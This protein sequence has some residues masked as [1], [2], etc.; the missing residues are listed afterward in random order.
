ME[1]TL[2]PTPVRASLKEEWVAC[3][4]YSM[5]FDRETEFQIS[6]GELL[7]AGSLP[8][9][10]VTSASADFANPEAY[11]LE[12]SKEGI[13]VTAGHDPGWLYAAVTLLHLMNQ[14]DGKLPL[15]SLYDYP[16]MGHRAM[17]LTFAQE[18]VQT[19]MDYLRY[20]L[21]EMAK[22]KL[23]AC[24]LYLETF[25]EFD[26]LKGFAGPGAMKVE[27]AKELVA[28]GRR[29]NIQVIPALNVMGHCGDLLD[30][31]R[32]R[33]L[34][35]VNGRDYDLRS[36]GNTGALCARN[37]KVREFIGRLL[38]EACEVF[39][40]ELIH[41]GGDE[42]EV[43][44]KCPLCEDG[45]PLKLYI[46]YF[47]FVRD[48]LRAH[49]RRMGIW[50]DILVHHC[51]REPH[52]DSAR[53]LS[54]LKENTVI[55]DWSYNGSTPET[56]EYFARNG[57]TVVAASSCNS[58]YASAVWMD[59]AKNI[60]A[61]FAD[62]QRLNLM[63]GLT[64]D[65]I[66][67]LANHTEQYMALFAA[68]AE[69][70]WSGCERPMTS[71]AR[72]FGLQKYGIQG[73]ALE[74]WFALTGDARSRLLRCFEQRKNGSYL[75]HCVY[76][77]D[78][79][80]FF[81]KHNCHQMDSWF[82]DYAQAVQEIA[83]HYGNKLIPELKKSAN[84]YALR[85]F[86][87]PLRIHIFLRAE[88]QM[89]QTLYA[90]YDRAAGFQYENPEAFTRE[91]EA[92]A[93]LAEAFIPEVGRARDYAQYCFDAFGVEYGSVL[94]LKKTEENC[95]RLAN[96]LRHLIKASHRPLP[97]FSLLIEMLFERPESVFWVNRAH[98]FIYDEYDPRYAVSGD[99]SFSYIFPVED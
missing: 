3:S 21:H 38:D 75:R 55:F 28:L 67:M 34:M 35:E 32:F 68:T 82:D 74:K 93:Q 77:T 25:I 63:G 81:W 72:R 2:I 44:G 91:M 92:C 80:L 24:Y 5:A 51:I 19:R 40:S 23:N 62:A 52:P 64:C 95:V 36:Y 89:A 84:P 58:C 15:G 78:N 20:A 83:E 90:A 29:L 57:F 98:D 6:I 79:P 70:L 88:Y 69:C 16:R 46:D 43:L 65:W 48:R 87:G 22:L 17:Q 41:V 99:K 71:I 97:A 26:C 86:E 96:Y 14:F 4:G 9:R 53:L 54:A 56:L 76:Y 47:G 39:P 30:T 66:N 1:L 12:I 13:R 7:P 42:V 33:S 85:V 27:E 11:S 50:G 10:F 45:E 37:P 8:L 49:G 61:L 73:D 31:Q 18:H 94:R 60:R 59:Q